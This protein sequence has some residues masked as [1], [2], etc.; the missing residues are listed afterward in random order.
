MKNWR[1]LLRV[2]SVVATGWLTTA[3][4]SESTEKEDPAEV[5]IRGVEFVRIPAGD[6]WYAVEAGDLSQQK[7]PLDAQRFRDVR[8][9][10]DAF[11]VAKYEA[12]IGDF[13]E[14]MNS[15]AATPELRGDD[16]ARQNEYKGCTINFEPGVGY[17]A[18]FADPNLP[19]TSMTWFL[20]D[21]FSRWMGFRLPSEAEWQKAARGTDRRIWPWGDSYPDDTRALFAFGRDCRAAPVTS[22]PKGRSPYG[23]FNMAGN[24]A[25]WTANWDNLDFDIGLRDGAHN[26]PLPESGTVSRGAPDP[27]RIIKGGRWGGGAGSLAIAPRRVN[28]PKDYNASIG[29][30][31]AIDA[32]T[33]RQLLMNGQAT[34]LTE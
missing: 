9:W 34:V 11:Y 5:R 6:F 27:G 25:E 15:A 21:A 20:A 10:L 24:V 13:I 32:A 30:R 31:F 26:P 23:I 17:K 7:L 18:R 3:I 33:V 8:V 16:L 2:L 29:V 28:S 14:F 1:F 12:R 19:A 22:Y 4:G